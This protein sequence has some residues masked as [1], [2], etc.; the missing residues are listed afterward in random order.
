MNGG[1]LKKIKKN[2][3]INLRIR[4]YYD[5]KFKKEKNNY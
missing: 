4:S 2:F 5:N 1:H 3:K